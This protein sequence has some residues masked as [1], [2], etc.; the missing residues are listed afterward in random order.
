MKDEKPVTQQS[1][2]ARLATARAWA[3][4]GGEAAENSS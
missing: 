4:P 3:L 2:C 1:L